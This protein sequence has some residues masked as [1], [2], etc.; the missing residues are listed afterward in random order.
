[1]RKFYFLPTALLLGL[2]ACNNAGD[3]AASSD[4]AQKAGAGILCAQGG[5]GR[6]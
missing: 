6:R 3:Q 5:C 2:A 4:S 1:M